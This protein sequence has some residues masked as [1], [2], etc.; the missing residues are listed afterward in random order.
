MA[1]II[2]FVGD[3]KNRKNKTAQ[4]LTLR[5]CLSKSSKLYCL[6]LLFPYTIP[7]PGISKHVRTAAG[8]A[9]SP[10]YTRDHLNSNKDIQH[11]SGACHF[12]NAGE[13]SLRPHDGISPQ[14]QWPRWK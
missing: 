9:Q 12:V 8:P 5:T 2:L 7:E 1:A 11:T 4:F 13:P 6:L 10:T 3:L 14:R